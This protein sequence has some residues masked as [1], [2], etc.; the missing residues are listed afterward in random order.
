MEA[1]GFVTH[2]VAM[3]SIVVVS[4]FCQGCGDWHGKTSGKQG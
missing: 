3:V 1:T 2:A 4:E